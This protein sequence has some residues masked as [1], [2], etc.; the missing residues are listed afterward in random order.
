MVPSDPS[1][2]P[3]AKCQPFADHLCSPTD[4]CLAK[5][6]L[7]IEQ[8][9]WRNR[10]IPHDAQHTKQIIFGELNTRSVTDNARLT[11][12]AGRDREL[13]S[14]LLLFHCFRTGGGGKNGGIFYFFSVSS[15]RRHAHLSH[16][17]AGL[18]AVVVV[19]ELVVEN[20]SSSCRWTSLRSGGCPL[21][22]FFPVL[23]FH[24]GTNKHVNLKEQQIFHAPTHKHATLPP[25]RPI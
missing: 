19:G 6:F 14:F 8:L 4:P 16:T 9:L 11:N 17:D 20:C 23:L 25:R 5:S 21:C 12:D 2:P 13:S 22:H 7:I 24:I 18:V 10:R 3:D 15:W 1:T